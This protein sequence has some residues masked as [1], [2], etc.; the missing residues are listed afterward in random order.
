MPRLRQYEITKAADMVVKSMCKIQPD[1]TV[2]IT[3]DTLCEEDVVEALAGA[4]HSLGAKVLVMW[5]PTPRGVGKDADQDVHYKALGEAI[6]ASDVWI[7]VGYNWILYSTAQEIAVKRNPN[8]R[9]LNMV[10]MNR[11][12]FIRLMSGFD[13][14]LLGEFQEKLTKMTADSTHVRITNPAGTDLEFDNDDRC[15]YY[16]ELGLLTKPGTA[17]LPGQIC[18]FP[19]NETIQGKLV[20]DGS[21]CPP[22][23]K[24]TSPIELTI[25][26]GYVVKV[27]GGAEAKQFES[28]LAN[29]NDPLMYRMAHVCYGVHPNAQLT[30]VC[31]EDERIWGSTEWGIGYLPACDAPPE[32]IDAASHCDGI[33]L[34]C[35][36]W[37]DGVQV[38]DQGEIVHPDLLEMAKK[39]HG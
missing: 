27:E 20:Y 13:A 18:W 3:A 5:Y 24:L 11:E 14:D 1:E 17:Y 23:G 10:G 16:C 6:G 8:L 21:L 35:S 15:P 22:C 32:G 4:V 9:H 37:L 33:S 38:L 29:F 19:I 36:V 31:V 25:K 34:A 39:L 7:E 12:M 26:D 2:A 30:G 28:W